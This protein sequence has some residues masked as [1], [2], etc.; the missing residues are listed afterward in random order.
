MTIAKAIIEGLAETA[1]AG[2]RAYA[3]SPKAAQYGRGRSR[4][5]KKDGCTPCAA[6]N[7]GQATKERARGGSL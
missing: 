2:V 3:A 4:G 6:F 5:K 7:N 1:K